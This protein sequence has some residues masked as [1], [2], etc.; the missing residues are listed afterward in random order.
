MTP[1][2][3]DISSARNGKGGFKGRPYISFIFCHF[4]LLNLVQNIIALKIQS[5]IIAIHM[6][7]TPS[8]AHFPKIMPK[9]TRKAH[10]DITDT[11]IVYFTSFP[12]LKALGSVKDGTHKN[13][14]QQTCIVIRSLAR[15]RVSS[16]RT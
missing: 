10:I 3:A 1:F 12:A 14:A 5:I 15:E 6:P 2:R 8:P 7:K 13:M 9:R 11:V 16:E 4:L